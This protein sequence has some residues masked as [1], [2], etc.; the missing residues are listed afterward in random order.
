MFKATDLSITVIFLA[1]TVCHSGAEVSLS[2]RRITAQQSRTIRIKC[3]V[4]AENFVAWQ[5]PSREASLGQP[6]IKSKYIT[7]GQSSGRVRV[8]STGNYYI[9]VI[10]DVTVRD[11]GKYTCIGSSQSKSFTL[12]VDFVSHGVQ[13]PQKL[14]QEQIGTIVL[15]VSAYPPLQYQWRKD[16]QPLTFPMDGKSIDLYSG[17]IK[18]DR[19]ERGDEGNYT[20]RVVWKAGRPRE[21]E[22]TVEVQV[23]VVGESTVYPI[24]FF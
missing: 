4:T 2:F 17:S 8:E 22:D 3:N 21:T 10:G 14:K 12:E 19:V 20:C 5:T 23:L 9:L 16:G 18:I 1:V 24:N 7:V 11:G 13:T 6:A 15:G